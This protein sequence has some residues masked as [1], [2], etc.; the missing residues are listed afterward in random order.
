MNLVFNSLNPEFQKTLLIALL[1]VFE[2]AC[3]HQLNRQSVTK[4]AGREM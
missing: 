1:S 2:H 3:I 4:F